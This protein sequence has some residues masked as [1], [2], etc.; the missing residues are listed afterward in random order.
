MVQR[1]TMTMMINLMRTKRKKKSIGRN[2]MPS[3]WLK[4][5]T[6][7]VQSGDNYNPYYLI[8]AA[9]EVSE[10]PGK[11]KDDYAHLCSGFTLVGG[12]N[13]QKI[14]HYQRPPTTSK[15]AIPLHFFAPKMLI[16]QLSCSFWSFRPKCLPPPVH[17]KWEN[18]TFW[19]GKETT[20]KVLWK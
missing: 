8:W 20:K 19:K 9:G 13:Y 14:Y 11:I 2:L 16:L 3:K 1:K 12:I 7:A 10:L 5:E 18:L 17:H 6:L 4:K 15:M